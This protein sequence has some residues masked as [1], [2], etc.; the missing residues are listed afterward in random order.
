[1]QAWECKYRWPLINDQL[2]NNCIGFCRCRKFRRS[3]HELPDM[4]GK[5]ICGECTLP[6]FSTGRSAGPSRRREAAFSA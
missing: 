6:A 1:M 3:K 4:A 5:G 2:S